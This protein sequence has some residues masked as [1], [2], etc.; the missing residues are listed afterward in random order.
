VV[1]SADEIA[2]PCAEDGAAVVLERVT[3]VAAD[4]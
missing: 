2:P 1:A 4:P 3:G